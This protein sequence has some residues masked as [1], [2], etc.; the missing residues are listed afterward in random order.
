MSVAMLMVVSLSAQTSNA[1][2]PQA[3]PLDPNAAWE[4]RRVVLLP[5]ER[6]V[7]GDN[8]IFRRSDS[9]HSMSGVEGIWTRRL[10][11]VFSR[12]LGVELIESQAVPRALMRRDSYREVLSLARERF[13][14]GVEA[15]KM[16]RIPDAISHLERALQLFEDGLLDFVHPGQRADIAMYRGITLT[17]Q[18]DLASA[19]HAFRDM[20]LFDPSRRFKRGYYPM[21][22]EGVIQ[23]AYDEVFGQPSI[24]RLRYPVERLAVL[25]EYVKADVWLIPT[26]VGTEGAPSLEVIGLDA[27]GG[28]TLFELSIPLGNDADAL[29]RLDREVSA[30][31]V[32]SNELTEPSYD[33]PLLTPRRLYVDVGYTHM[34]FLR[35]ERTTDF[36]QMPGV[37]ITLTYEP[38]RFVQTHLSMS[39][40]AAVPDANG[41]LLDTF[42]MTRLSAG[43]GIVG[44]SDK[45][46][47]FFSA[48]LDVALSLTDIRMSKDTRCKHWEGPP[49]CDPSQILLDKAT[50]AWV[51]L[52]L[53][54]GLKWV[55]AEP[56]Y[57]GVKVDLAT[58]LSE[59]TLA[60]DLN[61]P[62]GGSVSVGVRF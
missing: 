2:T 6:F 60:E 47:G 40:F 29:E 8:G 36:F 50:G 24:G 41:D 33:R 62:L 46:R 16:L 1:V 17:E 45:L 12:G 55:F 53:S 3:S 23:A 26:L 37:G 31:F 52:I 7:T 56:W 9:A 58:Y 43:V 25:A 61:F 59:G 57:L 42:L 35:H 5:L 19:L 27:S 30:W 48:G 32:C 10:E 39:Y 49:Q 44:G 28:D 13:S 18:D 51:G 38:A 15:F 22:I 21:A 54:S 20:W 34:S 14:L 11:E 4:T